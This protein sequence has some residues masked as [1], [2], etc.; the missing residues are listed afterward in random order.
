MKLVIKIEQC[1]YAK[2]QALINHNNYVIAKKERKKEKEI[3]ELR[4]VF[5]GQH[6]SMPM[7]HRDQHEVVQPYPIILYIQRVI[8]NCSN[9]YLKIS[10]IVIVN[11]EREQK[12]K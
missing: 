4:L 12:K 11:S 7:N 8:K 1:V 6:R 5:H 2:G 3:P 10:K 9:E